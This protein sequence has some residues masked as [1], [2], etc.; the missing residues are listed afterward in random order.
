IRFGGNMTLLGHNP[1]SIGDSLQAG[2]V[3]TLAIYWRVDGLLLPDT[4][5][6]IRL[7]DTPQAS[8]YAE[9]NAFGVDPSRLQGRDVVLQVGYLTIPES[10]RNQEYRLTIGVYDKTPVNQLPVYDEVTGAIRGSYLMLG[11]P[12]TVLSH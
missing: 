11:L 7:H 10:I 4:G 1:L 6:F 8:P 3:L 9:T 12:F 5:I 2:D